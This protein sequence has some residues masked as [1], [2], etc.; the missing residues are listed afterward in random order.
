[1]RNGW[2]QRTI[3]ISILILLVSIYL[4]YNFIINPRD[5]LGN[6]CQ[7]LYN[8]K[9]Y[10]LVTKDKIDIPEK[11][12]FVSECCSHVATFRSKKDYESLTKELENLE[13]SLNSV[14]SDLE[15]EIKVTQHDF[16]N[17]Y[18]IKYHKNK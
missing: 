10:E 5:E 1:M 17:T 13:K 18:I 8:Q 9:Q 14:Y 12:C 4:V 11:S 3:I 15:F 16:Y 6:R 7:T 2:K